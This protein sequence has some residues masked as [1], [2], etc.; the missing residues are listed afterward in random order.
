[1]FIRH[2]FDSKSGVGGVRA[3]LV[4]GGTSVETGVSASDVVKDEGA[5]SLLH[6]CLHRNTPVMLHTS[7]SKVK[8]QVN[9]RRRRQ[10]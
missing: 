10:R 3:G 6:I 1:M 4:G 2:T 8:V 7:F 5:P 9:W